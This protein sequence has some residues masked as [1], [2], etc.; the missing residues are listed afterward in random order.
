MKREIEDIKTI[1][2]RYEKYDIKK[3]KLAIYKH[4]TQESISTYIDTS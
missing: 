2:P 4:N 3:K 1:E